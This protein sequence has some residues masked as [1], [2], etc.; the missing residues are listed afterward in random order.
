MCH[1]MK[2]E[3]NAWKN[4]VMNGRRGNVHNLSNCKRDKTFRFQRESS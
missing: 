4:D 2:T 1:D 3:K